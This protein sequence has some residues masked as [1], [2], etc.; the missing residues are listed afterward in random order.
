[1]LELYPA[2][3]FG[4]LE[5]FQAHSKLFSFP[6][7]FSFHP[8]SRLTPSFFP[9]TVAFSFH[10]FFL[11]QIFEGNS[12]QESV[13]S[14]ELVQ[15]VMAQYIRVNPQTWN[16][17]IALRTELYGHDAGMDLFSCSFIA[18]VTPEN[19]GTK[20]QQWLQLYNIHH[21]AQQQ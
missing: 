13:V 14:H 20:D 21:K 16:E 9:F 4:L 8:F 6:A 11:W 15:T 7:A 17:Q 2:Q 1:M 19:K 5:T 3:Y 10:C 12:D 18:L